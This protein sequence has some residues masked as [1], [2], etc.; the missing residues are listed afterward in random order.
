MRILVARAALLLVTLGVWELWAR[1]QN[2]L[3]FIPPS[4]IGPALGRLVRLE[5]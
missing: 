3:L 1:R 5:S 2:P 4:K